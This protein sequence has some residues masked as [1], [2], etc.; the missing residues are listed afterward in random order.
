MRRLSRRIL[1]A[2]GAAGLTAGADAAP[3]LGTV[4]RAAPR[5]S[6]A[7]LHSRALHKG[8]FYG[9]AVDFAA[10]R[11]TALMTHVAAECGM[12]APGEQ[13]YLVTTAARGRITSPSIAPR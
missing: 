5:S 3:P 4:T 12:I 7:G 2:G 13:F 10:L 6:A 9:A 1:L 11:D 8:L